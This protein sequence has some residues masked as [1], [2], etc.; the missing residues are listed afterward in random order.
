MKEK[1]LSK[2]RLTLALAALFLSTCCTMGDLA[3][4]PIFST[5]YEIFD[6]V[7]VINM[8]TTGPGI[9]GVFFCLLGGRLTDIMDKKILMLIGFALH[10][11]SSVFGCLIVNQYYVMVCRLVSTGVAWGITSS[12][13]LGIIA[14]L[15]SDEAK[16]GTVNGWYN[17]VMAAMG[18]LLSFV[19]GM[20]AVNGWQNAYK[21][22]WITIPILVM[23]VLF[24]PSMPP[25]KAERAATEKVKG[26]KG[27]YKNLI[28]LLIQ[29]ILIGTSYYVITYMISL[30]VAD[31]GIG[32]EAFT[33]TL[34]S[35][36]TITSCIAGLAFGFVYGKMKKAT[37]II[38]F[39]LLGIGFLIMGFVPSASVAVLCCAFMGIS[40]GIFY[41]FFYTE[42]SVVVPENM[43][44]TSI[45][46]TGAV[47]GLASFLCSYVLIGLEG[48]MN[49]DSSVTTFPV[50]GVVCLLVAAVSAVGI[51]K[52]RTAV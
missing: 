5:F 32:N 31:A 3:I 4:V 12:A 41:S 1:N 47:N 8:I 30:Y 25:R 9:I 13:A 33:G 44:G 26:E 35:I 18:A 34:S 16:R 7:F 10:V 42:C 40:W 46:I 20:L 11:V 19:G 17:S 45:G 43:Q 24:L 29:V 50:F 52:N 38:P 22:Y 15:Y 27:W 36:G 6:N 48:A 14:E 39:I 51:M 21:T 37:P 28:P 2:A 23:L 49:T